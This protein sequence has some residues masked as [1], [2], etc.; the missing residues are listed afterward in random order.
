MRDVLQ[1]DPRGPT[2]SGLS[3]FHRGGK[4]RVGVCREVRRLQRWMHLR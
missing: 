3:S 2:P 4:S 1:L